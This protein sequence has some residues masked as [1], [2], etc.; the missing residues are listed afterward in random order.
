MPDFPE[1]PERA[2]W[3]LLDAFRHLSSL[4]STYERMRGL[5]LSATSESRRS[6]RCCPLPTAAS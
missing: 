1:L 3:L 4:L 5:F 2:V 6:L